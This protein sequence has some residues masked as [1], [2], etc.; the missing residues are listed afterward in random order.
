[1]RMRLVSKSLALGVWLVFSAPILGVSTEGGAGASHAAEKTIRAVQT[2][3]PPKIDGKLDDP[4]WKQAAI[5]TDFIQTY[6][7]EGELAEDTGAQGSI[8]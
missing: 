5:A 2:E 6:P 4:C 7:D 1:M 3:I 8:R